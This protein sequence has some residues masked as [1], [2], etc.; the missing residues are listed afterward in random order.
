MLLKEPDGTF[1]IT[2]NEINR[3]VCRLIALCRINPTSKHAKKLKKQLERLEK[4]VAKGKFK[5]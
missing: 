1:E 2:Q 3:D 5:N 4:A